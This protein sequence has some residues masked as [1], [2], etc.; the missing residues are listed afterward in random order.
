MNIELLAILILQVLNLIISGVVPPISN[1]FDRITS[2]ECCGLKL[3][4]NLTKKKTMRN[5][6]IQEDGKNN[7]N[8]IKIDI[9]EQ[10][11]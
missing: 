9:N 2:S 5:K 1:F 8:E 4:R 6:R 10:E 7:N 11:E 3:K